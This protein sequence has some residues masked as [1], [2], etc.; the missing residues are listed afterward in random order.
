MAN[1]TLTLFNGQGNSKIPF[2]SYEDG[3]FIF[4]NKTLNSL[5]DAY[6]FTIRNYTLS[7]PL[8]L[9][10][11]I[12]TFRT[13][14]D[15]KDY[16]PE[17]INNIAINLTEVQNR[18]DV[19]DIIEYFFNKNYAC[20][21]GQGSDYDGHK[22]FH[23]Q[24]IIKVDFLTDETTIK[25]SLMVM[26]SELGVKCRVD[27]Q[28]SS[29]ISVQPPANSS[30]ILHVRENGKVLSNSLSA[31]VLSTKHNTK[32]LKV[33]FNDDFTELCLEQFA[34]LGFHASSAE[35]K[36]KAIS[37][38]RKYEDNTKKGFY[39]FLDNPLVMNHKTR[40]SS[41]SIYHLMKH[42][43]EGKEWLKN[44]TKEEQA[45]QLIK[46]ENVMEYKKYLAV[47]ER[48][49]DFTKMNKEK[50]VNDFLDSD[51]GVFKLKSPMGTAKSAGIE[52]IIKKA[53][54]RGEKVIIVSNRISVAKDFAEKY[55]LLLYQDPD[56]VTSKDSIVV[57]YDSLHKYDLAKYDIAIFDEYISLLLH[58]RSNLNTNS[59]INAVKFKILSDRK[60]VVIADAFLT[61]YDIEFFKERDIYFINNEYKD[62]IKL[63]DYNQKE[64]FITQLIE[65]S[66]N[67]KDGEHISASFTSLNIIKL[68]EYELREAGI[69][70]VSLTSETAELTR[71]IIYK[72]FKEDTHSA[73]QVILFTPT[74]TVGVSNLNN[75]VSHFHY[76]SSMGA[77]VI[78]SL[79]MIKRSRTAR[80][81]HYF[82]Q[83]RQNHF[84]TNLE[85]LN[86]NAQRNISQ[87]YNNR[88]KTLLVDIDYESG[89]LA[90]TDLAKYINKIEAFYNVLA[91]NHANAF[92]LL[93]SYQ[94]KD[95]PILVETEDTKFDIR[96]KINKIKAKIRK[97][98]MDILE[99][100]SEVDW[101]EEELSYIKNKISQKTPEEQAKLM[102]GTIQEKFSKSIPKNKLKE[103]TRL[104]L[105]SNNKFIQQVK[106]TK[107]VM[108][109]DASDYS[110]Y[111]LSEAISSD[112]SSLQNKGHIRFLENLLK[113]GSGNILD[114]AYSKNDVLK[115]NHEVFDGK[116]KFA[117]F[118]GDMG[119]SWNTHTQ[120]Y[121]ADVKVFSYIDYV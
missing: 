72:K 98:N 93:L 104:E 120:T 95:L 113:F 31:P 111:Q 107:L 119:Y 54:G 9:K 27:L 10:E 53:H 109:S 71:D 62:D 16:V 8:D 110:K 66:K 17:K 77:D 39:W 68:V 46:Q 56:S 91:N 97:A 55:D 100:Y 63:Y 42:T 3:S 85:S 38:Y 96:D 99:E 44:K 101:T 64:Y 15:L 4:A 79:Q 12:N 112:I 51:K 59:N 6:E 117:K 32:H 40:G 21:I 84:D 25:N 118:L 60:R 1:I 22:N 70:V 81:I 88:D 48:Y 75:V 92:R 61:G 29:I 115:I 105:D 89:N 45:H 82:I 18:Y 103:L 67:L 47:N 73:F 11:P 30:K 20:I 80:E 69:K 36:G 76:D 121:N 19:D 33:S 58:H 116:R 108:K 13:K 34:Q 52:L 37:F 23:L 78:S 49:L 65:Q 41:V 14:T 90:L 114:T 57:Q 94:F 7:R 26:Q 87:Y 5:R 2:S 43:K 74:L 86:I 102:M 35:A 24:G 106:N 50:V 83:S 28:A